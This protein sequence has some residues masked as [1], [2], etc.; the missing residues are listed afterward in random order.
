MSLVGVGVKTVAK[1]EI[2]RQGVRQYVAFLSVHSRSA[3]L[4]NRPY[5]QKTH[6]KSHTKKLCIFT[7]GDAC[8]PYATCM[9]TLLS[10]E[11]VVHG[12]VSEVSVSRTI[13]KAQLW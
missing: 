10:Q 8:A 7:T 3:A 1:R 11:A 5:N 6:I 12:Q 13:T 4:P 9:A 2:F